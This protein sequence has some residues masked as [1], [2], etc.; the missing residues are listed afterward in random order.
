M[1][2]LSDALCLGVNA[3]FFYPPL[4]APSPNP[5]YALGKYVCYACP[6]WRECLTYCNKNDETW[7]LWGGLS[8]QERKK[9]GTLRH[10][11]IESKRNNCKCPECLSAPDWDGVYADTKLLPRAGEDYDLMTLVYEITKGQS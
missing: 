6:V 1:D 2:W 7:G 5:Y 8:P 10:G 9:P 4:D 11:S 3:D